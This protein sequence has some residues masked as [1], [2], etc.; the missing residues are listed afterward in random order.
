MVYLLQTQLYN[1]LLLSRIIQYKYSVD[2]FTTNSGS[3]RLNFGGFACVLNYLNT[4]TQ[5]TVF[6]YFFEYLN[7]E[8]F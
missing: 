7:T 8:Y 4:Y 6:K 2:V 3:C 1:H 5:N